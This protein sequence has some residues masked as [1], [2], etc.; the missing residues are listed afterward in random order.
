MG[1][2][3]I[4]DAGGR[5]VWHT[6]G[7]VQAIGIVFTPMIQVSQAAIQEILR[8]GSK[9]TATVP[10][11][12]RLS[13]ERKGCLSRSYVMAFDS[14]LSVGDQVLVISEALAVVYN[15]AE[16]RYLD[17]LAIDY[18]EDLMG[19]GFRFHNPNASQVC[20]CGNSFATAEVN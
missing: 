2:H 18:S 15:S 19:G 17:G 11:R 5:V 14:Q 8:L 12:F 20:S 3:R 9:H 7:K 13:T 1:N 16:Q 10:L 4:A 6:H